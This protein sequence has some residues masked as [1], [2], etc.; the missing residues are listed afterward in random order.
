MQRNPLFLLIL[1]VLN[2]MFLIQSHTSLAASPEKRVA[3][4]IGNSAYQ[5][6]PPL[7]NPRNDATEM[8]KALKRV[9]FDVDLVVDATKPDMDQALRRFGNNLTGSSAAVFYYAGHGIQVDGI[10]YILPVDVTLKNERDLNWET[11]DMTTV[12]KQMEGHNRVNLLFLDACRDNPLSQTLARSMGE[13]RSS[14]IGRGLATMKANAGTLISY[15][16][17]EGEVAADGRGKHS[18]YT[19]ALLK[20][21]EMPGVEIGLLLRKVR[22]DVIAATKNKQVPWEYGS[23]LGEFYF[24]GPVTIQV[25]PEV[26]KSATGSK[27]ESLYWESIMN[28]TDPAAFEEY[29]K[30]YPDGEFSGLARYKIN[31]L[32]KGGK[33]PPPV[34]VIPQSEQIKPSGSLNIS[35]DPSDALVVLDGNPI[36]YTDMEISGVDVGNRKIEMKKDCFETKTIEVFINSNQQLKLNLKLKPSCGAISVTSNPVGA[37]ILMNEKLVGVTPAE[38]TELK[39]GT[40]TISLK[41]EGYEEW[42]DTATVRAVKTVLIKA[43]L[44]MKAVVV[45]KPPAQQ[46]TIEIV[47][48][49]VAKPPAQ[50]P[51]IEIVPPVAEH[52]VP[53]LH[54]TVEATPSD[55]HINILNIQGKY[56]KGMV[57]KPGK[58][59][60][61][62]LRDGYE[63]STQWITMDQS[64]IVLPVVLTPLQKEN[65]RVTGESSGADVLIDKKLADSVPVEPSGVSTWNQQAPVKKPDHDET[66]AVQAGKATSATE[67]LKQSSKYTKLDVNS[68]HLPNS[69]QSWMMVLDNETSLIWEVKQ[70]KD[71]I[72]NYDNPNDADNKYLSHESDKKFIKA[73]NAANWGGFSDWRIPSKEELNTLVDSKGTKRTINTAYF[74]NTQLSSYWSSG[75]ERVDFGSS[76]DYGYGSNRDVSDSKDHGG[77]VRAVRGG[78]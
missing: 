71:G 18:P 58:Y 53:E 52:K 21:I 64:D 68:K 11:S 35:S 40:Y 1:A 27:N 19:E 47:P 31:S 7:A 63:T 4:V 30:K 12:L 73:L 45:A 77:Y 59:Q 33:K 8:G 54:F 16:T 41:K 9:G 69:A 20:H 74:P 55:S 65:L 34:D 42:K 17:K 28:D 66:V 44:L 78:K 24:T 56:H 29:L 57:L 50:Q 26:S 46:P 49:V 23:L 25:Q 72:N 48:P 14:V 3:L 61:E 76:P 70:N 36:G 22:E 15:S 75:G 5:N 43:D 2:L 51:T 62:V 32:I 10:N 37:D 38:L 6:T 39:P 67:P 13:S 60:V